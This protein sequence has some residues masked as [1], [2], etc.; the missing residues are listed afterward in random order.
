[1]ADYILAGAHTVQIYVDPADTNYKGIR[2]AAEAFAGDVELVTGKKPELVEAADKITGPV[3]V[4]G[5]MKQNPLIAKAA[6]A[7]VLNLSEIDGK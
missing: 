3:I 1:M 6:E 7:G 4:V 5:T 2:I